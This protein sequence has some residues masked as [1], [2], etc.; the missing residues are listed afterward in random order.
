MNSKTFHA[1]LG[2]TEHK[3]RIFYRV[4]QIISRK[5]QIF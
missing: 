5:L 2:K 4:N 3:L 1:Y